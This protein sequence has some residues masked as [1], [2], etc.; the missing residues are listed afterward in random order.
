MSFL[1]F[2]KN[3]Q[4]MPNLALEIEP[5]IDEQ[6]LFKHDRY[7]TT[8]EKL[9]FWVSLTFMGLP[10]EL[11]WRIA[12]ILTAMFPKPVPKPVRKLTFDGTD[13]Y[14]KR[15][16]DYSDL[17]GCHDHSYYKDTKNEDKNEDDESYYKRM[18]ENRT[19]PNDRL[20]EWEKY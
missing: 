20:D 13:D 3:A 17:Y 12:L 6:Y 4:K 19:D 11:N 9:Q 18:M 15:W 1:S 5:A 10:H 16:D 2:G 14:T 7:P 8:I